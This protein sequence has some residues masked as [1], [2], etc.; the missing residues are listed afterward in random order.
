MGCVCI[1]TVKKAVQV[2]IEKY[3]T[4]LG[5]NL[6]TKCVCEEFAAILSKKLQQD[7][8]LCHTYEV[9]AEMPH[10]KYLNQSVGGGERK[11]R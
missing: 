10:E 11:G 6:H 7:S 3:Y 9:D 4:C 1:K 5:N 2:I 8:R